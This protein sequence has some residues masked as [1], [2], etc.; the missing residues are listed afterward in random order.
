[1]IILNE[2]ELAEGYLHNGIDKDNPVLSLSILAKYFCHVMHLGRKQIAESLIAELQKSYMAYAYN[3]GYWIELVD[4]LAGNAKKYTLHEIDGVRITES[5][6]NT[7]LGIKDKVLERLAFTV[8][9]IAKLNNIKNPNNNGWV[10]R[11]D[12]EVFKT[13]RIYG[14][15]SDKRMRIGALASL[16]LVELSNRIDGMN[17]RVTFIDDESDERLF[18]SDFR[19]LGY[20][21]MLYRGG[22]LTRCKECDILMPNNKNKTKKY[23]SSCRAPEI[24]G[25]KWLTC[26]QC[27]ES[28]E[29]NAKNN[30]TK[31]CPSCQRQFDIIHRKERNKRYWEKNKTL[32]K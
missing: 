19:E 6:L 7:I 8:L 23:C 16:G 25:T 5:E 20:E 28:F 17:Y 1:M 27:G 18:I 9:C 14:S 22:N 10:N 12:K 3:K 30:S 4:K 11:E 15:A 24:M 32:A 2:R 13:A 31:N 26:Q 29:V 21:Y